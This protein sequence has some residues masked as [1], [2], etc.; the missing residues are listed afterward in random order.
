MTGHI[1]RRVA[2]LF[3][4]LCLLLILY[5]PGTREIAQ[6]MALELVG[7]PVSLVNYF[8]DSTLHFWQDYIQEIHAKELYKKLN[9]EVL[10]L[11][12]Q[13][14]ILELLLK[15]KGIVFQEEDIAQKYAYVRAKII[16]YQAMPE[17][18]I[19]ILNKGMRDGI[20]KSMPVI[21][22]NNLV[23]KVVS[24]SPN[25]SKLMFITDINSALGAMLEDTKEKGVLVGT[26]EE[27]CELK[28]I[29]LTSQVQEGEGVITS[30]TDGIFPP[31]I[32]VGKVVLVERPKVGKWCKIKVKPVV[33]FQKISEVV[34]L[35]KEEE[36]SKILKEFPK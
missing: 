1:I 34:V 36:L 27:L 29:P 5:R 17:P 8:R 32:M 13:N 24:T 28:Y 21:I 7:P 14:Q 19:A 31:Y 22:Q 10:E 6:K 12:R 16:G 11:K 3:I 9:K 2:L 15:E 35:L 26:S 30:G 4:F 20:K 23:G 25:Y 33:E 18:T